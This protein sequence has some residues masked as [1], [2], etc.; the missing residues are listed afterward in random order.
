MGRVFS[1]CSQGDLPFPLRSP[2]I[3]APPSLN[4]AFSSRKRLAPFDKAVNSGRGEWGVSSGS[5][6]SAALT[7]AAGERPRETA[8][9]T[10]RQTQSRKS[11]EVELD[12]ETQEHS[13]RLHTHRHT[14]VPGVGEKE[15]RYG[16]GERHREKDRH[17]DIHKK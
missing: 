12:T 15:Q 5:L 13:T 14:H 9:K 11:I 7:D 6:Q 17:T 4:E 16:S 8:L 1:G 10:D 3:P 2:C